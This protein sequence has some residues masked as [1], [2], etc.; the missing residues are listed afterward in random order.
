LLALRC[1]LEQR[2]AATYRVS[3][4]TRSSFILGNVATAARGTN[5]SWSAS[6][7]RYASFTIFGPNRWAKYDVKN[8]TT[9]LHARHERS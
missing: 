6:P 3:T 4:P 1:T 5:P 7:M 9:S 2:D 8:V